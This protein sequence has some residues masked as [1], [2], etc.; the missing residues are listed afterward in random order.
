[1]VNLPVRVKLQPVAVRLYLAAAAA[2][3]VAAAAYV[4]IAVAVVVAAVVTAIVAGAVVAGAVVADSYK[5]SST[6]MEVPLLFVALS[7]C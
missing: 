5:D 1:M 3:A 7:S 6:L 2:A 4:V